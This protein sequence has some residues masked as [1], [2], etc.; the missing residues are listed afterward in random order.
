MLSQE[1]TS[2][3]LGVYVK[4]QNIA[5]QPIKQIYLIW[6][7]RNK[8]NSINIFLSGIRNAFCS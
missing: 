1:C 8:N 5:Y 4:V 3:M 6:T 7:D 2:T